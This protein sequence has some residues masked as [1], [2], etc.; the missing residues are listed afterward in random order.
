[1]VIKGLYRWPTGT[2]TMNIKF[3]EFSQLTKI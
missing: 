3:V 2:S 1:M